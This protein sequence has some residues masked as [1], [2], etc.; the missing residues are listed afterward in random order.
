MMLALKI[1][2]EPNNKQATYLAKACCTARFAYNWALAEWKRQHGAGRKTSETKLRGELNAIKRKQFPWMMEVTK[3]APQ[4]AI[5][6]LG[7]AFTDFFAGR[8]AFAQFKKKGRKDSFALS[9]DQFK[10]MG[11]TISIPNL[12]FARMAEEL[13]FAGNLSTKQK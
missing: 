2:L 11:K 7:K 5:M 12:G 3:R 13:R 6:D 9:N 8:A 10:V 4:L 1:R